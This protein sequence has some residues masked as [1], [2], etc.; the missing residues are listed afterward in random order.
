MH[1]QLTDAQYADVKMVTTSGT[2]PRVDGD[3]ALAPAAHALPRRGRGRSAQVRPLRLEARQPGRQRR[4]RFTYE[5]ET[6]QHRE[7]GE[8]RRASVRARRRDEGA[9]TSPTVRASTASTIETF[10]FYKNADMKGHLGPR[11]AVHHRALAA[12]ATA[13]VIRKSKDDFKEGWVD[14]RGTDR[15]AAVS[16]Y[17]FAQRAH[18][19]ERRRPRATSSPRTGSPTARSATTTRPA[20]S[21]T[22]ASRTTRRRSTRARPPTYDA[23]RL[24]RPEG[25]RHPQD[26]GRPGQEARRP[27]QPRLLLARREG[28][29]RLARRAQESRHAQLG[30]RD[31]RRSR[32][33]CGTILFPLRGSRSRRWSACAASS[34]SSTRSTRSSKATCRRRTSP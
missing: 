2:R 19:R 33:A 22:R 5:D 17:Y 24:P 27:H 26:R 1:F 32:C 9:R 34:P 18:P 12:R 15:Y 4:A 30:P 31:H 11:L 6:A 8:G 29:H 10:A 20:R 23:D 3:R 25:A 28:A 14:K 16:N 7:D 13:T 21:T